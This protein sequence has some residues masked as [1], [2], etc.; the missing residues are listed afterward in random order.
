MSDLPSEIAAEARKG[1]SLL[2][3]P[4]KAIAALVG[5]LLVVAML[6]VVANSKIDWF[7]LTKK[8]ADAAEA[9]ATAATQSSNLATNTVRITEHFHEKET[10]IRE[11]AEESAHAVEQ[12]PSDDVPG[13]VLDGWVRGLRDIDARATNSGSK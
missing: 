9:Q 10:I 5:L 11:K 1:W 8:R 13:P 4:G 3:T 2:P 6:I 12:I 7:G